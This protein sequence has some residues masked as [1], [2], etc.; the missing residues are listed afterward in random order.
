MQLPLQVTFRNMDPS[1]AIEANIQ[2]KANKLDA[3][4]DRIM[5]CRVVV[6][7]PHRHHHKGKLYHVRID[8]TVPGDELVINRE[9]SRHAAHE[10][11]YV[12][13]RDAFGAARRKL[14]DYARRQRGLVK[15]HSPAPEARI[16][17]VFLEEGYGFLQTP[18]GREVYFHRNSL[19]DLKF[20]ELEPGVEVRF[21]EVQGKEGPQASTVRTI[22]KKH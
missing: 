7:A 21:T 17:K 2:E 11:V 10:D 19:L 6:E 1:A 20:D 9:P 3:F 12:A 4:Y 8:M 16:S 22:P 5:G 14:Q 13:I 15:I 18:D